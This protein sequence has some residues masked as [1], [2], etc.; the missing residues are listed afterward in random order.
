MIKNV[1][2]IINGKCIP[3]LAH[4][5]ERVS[6]VLTWRLLFSN[7]KLL[8]QTFRLIELKINIKFT[9]SNHPSSEKKF[10][11]LG[12]CPGSEY[13]L[14]DIQIYLLEIL[15]DTKTGRLTWFQELAAD[16]SVDVRK[17]WKESSPVPAVTGVENLAHDAPLHDLTDSPPF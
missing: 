10:Y 16:V 1:L 15:N 9:K 3:V 13:K 6:E 8:F 17:Y 5:H 7:P 11:N 2:P 4:S 14:Q 12:A